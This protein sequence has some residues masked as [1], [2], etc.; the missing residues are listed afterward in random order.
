MRGVDYVERHVARFGEDELN[1]AMVQRL[2]EIADGTRE[3]TP[4][5]LNFYTHELRESVRYRKLG[6]KTGQPLDRDEA[7]RLW[8]NAHTATLEDYRIKEGPG[9]LYDLELERKQYE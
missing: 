8:N 3:A 6:W 5:D 4:T 1:K 2:R 7:Y 9:M